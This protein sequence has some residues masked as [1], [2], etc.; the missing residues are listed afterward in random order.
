M[1]IAPRRPATAPQTPG[2]RHFPQGFT[3][4]TATAAY[5]IEGAASAGGRTLHLG[6]LRAH[7]RPGAERRHR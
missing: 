4:G 5:Q 2:V 3:W 1:T 6:H 7:A